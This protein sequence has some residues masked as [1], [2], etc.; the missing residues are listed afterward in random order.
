M[1]VE[2]RGED[3]DVPIKPEHKM[4]LK[5]VRREV[6]PQGFTFKESLEFLP[7]QHVIIFEKPAQAAKPADPEKNAA[8]DAPAPNAAA[9][10][11]SSSQ[12]RSQ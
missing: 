1:L 3:P 12:D 2:F 4:T 8:G 11:N 5:Q 7:W 10:K 9:P 6:E